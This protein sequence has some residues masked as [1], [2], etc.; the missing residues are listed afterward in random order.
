M[1]QAILPIFLSL[2]CL[3]GVVL[4]WF[5]SGFDFLDRASLC[6]N[7]WLTVAGEIQSTM[8]EKAWK[9]KHEVAGHIVSAVKK[10]V[11]RT[12]GLPVK[13]ESLSPVI[14]FFQYDITS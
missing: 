9:K 3:F 5:G 7:P 4:V 12:A 13:P 14:P 6:N 1:A 8:V 10:N 11:D 2:F